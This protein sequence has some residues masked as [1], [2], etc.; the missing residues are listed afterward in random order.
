MLYKRGFLR[1]G[2]SISNLPLIAH[3]LTSILFI[4]IY[5][6]FLA[7]NSELNLNKSLI[8]YLHSL[9]LS[10]H[11]L[12][13][14]IFEINLKS[15]NNLASTKQLDQRFLWLHFIVESRHTCDHRQ[16]FMNFNWSRFVWFEWVESANLLF[17]SSPSDF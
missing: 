17:V 4:S 12:F 15:T 3:I 16:N 2:R 6:I 7:C 13:K 1:L 14:I 5:K 10:L 11:W 8:P 9:S